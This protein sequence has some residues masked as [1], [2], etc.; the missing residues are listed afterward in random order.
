MEICI[1]NNCTYSFICIMNY[2]KLK[3]VELAIKKRFVE[4]RAR[5]L[6]AVEACP[7]KVTLKRAIKQIKRFEAG[8]GKT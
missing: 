2:K 5:V 6:K 4:V 8:R 3:Q 7:K 1:F